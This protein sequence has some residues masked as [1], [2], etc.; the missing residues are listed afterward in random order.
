MTLVAVVRALVRAAAASCA[1]CS[2][3]AEQASQPEVRIIVRG[4]LNV[5]IYPPQ[6]GG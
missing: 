4:F 3:A 5:S 6:K 2:G 1:S